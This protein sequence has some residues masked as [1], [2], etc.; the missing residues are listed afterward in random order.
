MNFKKLIYLFIF[1]LPLI[2]I[3][4]TKLPKTYKSDE[5]FKIK[6]NETVKV[7][8][9]LKITF[10]GN[11]HKDV[12]AGGPESPLG[13]SFTYDFGKGTVNDEHWEY[14]KPPYIWKRKGYIFKIYK[15]EYDSWMEMKV[16]KEF[17]TS[18]N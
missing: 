11:T 8:D 3:S 9:S 7:G 13:V 2:G 5:K 17:N 18:K 14:N 6:L 10:V 4:Q 16:V 1:A 15:C 12:M